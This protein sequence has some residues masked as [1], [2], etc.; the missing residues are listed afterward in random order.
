MSVSKQNAL[1]LAVGITVFVYGKY[2]ADQQKI[3][4][5]AVQK[6]LTTQFFYCQYCAFRSC[7]IKHV[8]LFQSQSPKASL[9]YK[10]LKNRHP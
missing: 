9:T 6:V 8:V 5:L 2:M 7:E 10:R 3:I 1:M 4:I